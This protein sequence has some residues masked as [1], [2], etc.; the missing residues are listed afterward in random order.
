[1]NHKPM[2]LEDAKGRK[3]FAVY[4][5]PS[6]KVRRREAVILC[7]PG[8]EEYMRC[9]WPFRQLSN[10]L[11]ELGFPVLRLDYTGTGDSSG[12][13]GSGS[14]EEWSDNVV[15]AAK[16]LQEEAATPWISLIG[17]RLGGAV[18]LKAMQ[19]DL[20]IYNLILWDPVLD[21]ND[22]LL[23]LQQMRK[24]LEK[25][26]GLIGSLWQK[27]T[28]RDDETTGFPL[29]KKWQDDLANWK[30]AK[31]EAKAAR[32]Q[33]IVSD[34]SAKQSISEFVEQ[35]SRAGSAYTLHEMDEKAGWAD[36][37]AAQQVLFARQTIARIVDIMKGTANV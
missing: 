11:S 9:H 16:F 28:M 2:F 34:G 30:A 37:H 7:N 26:L 12:A 25:D 22:Y 5:P 32:G 33:Y 29:S 35:Q 13:N 8:L 23:Q 14:L 4:Y 15:A 6:G 1:M 17:I 3:I 24:T 21:G 18:A 20:P 31:I 10:L 36:F 19:K 27:V